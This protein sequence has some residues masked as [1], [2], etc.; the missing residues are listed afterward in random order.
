MSHVEPR[1]RSSSARPPSR[2]QEVQAA[3]ERRDAAPLGAE[4]VEHARACAACAETLAVS[5]WM[6]RAASEDAP[7]PGLPSASHLWW[8][9]RIIRDLV[10][11]ESRVKRATWPSLWLQGAGL[12]LLLLLA[13]TALTRLT[14]ALLGEFH[15]QLAAGSVSLTWIAALLLAGIALPVAGFAVLWAMWR[16]I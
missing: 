3:V 8:R 5:A 7:R 12:A 6:R 10:E 1:A 14:S 13:G 16:E 11:K 2:C 9:A 15:N 4:I